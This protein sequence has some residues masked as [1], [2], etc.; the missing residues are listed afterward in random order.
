MSCW[1]QKTFILETAREVTAGCADETEDAD[2][3]PIGFNARK[4]RR[5][6]LRGSASSFVKSASIREICGFPSCRELKGHGES[7]PAHFP[8]ILPSILA[9]RRIL[10]FELFPPMRFASLAPALLLVSRALAAPL[11]LDLPA[12]FSA[13]LVATPPLLKH[14]VMAA[15][16]EPGVLYVCDMAGVNLNKAELEEQRPNRV[17]RLVDENGDGIYEKHTVFAD[18]LTFPNG[19]VWLDGSLYVCSAPGVW[20]FTDADGDGVADERTAIASGFDYTGNAADLHGPWLHPNGRLYWCHG[21]KTFKA[22][23]SDG[24]VVAEGGASGIWSCRPDGLDL[25]WHSL[26]SGDNPV[27]ID[28]TPEG[29]IVGTMN[30]FYS[31]PRGDVI[32]HWLRGGVYPREDQMK[33]IDG[34]PRTLE[35]LPVAHNF[36]HVAVSGCAFHRSGALDPGWRGHLFVTHFNTGRLTRMELAR[37][38][39]SFRVAEREFLQMR[40]P[41]AHLTDVL[42]DRDGSLLVVDTGGWFRNGCPSSLI[43]KPEI[44]G[45][46][47]RIRRVGLPGK[48]ESWDAP[49]A[50]VWALARK[51]DARALAALLAGGDAQIARAAANALTEL[52]QPE[53]TDALLAAL[54]HRDPGVQLA[55]VQALGALPQMDRKTVGALLA[56]LDRELSP[57]VEHQTMDALIRGLA[58]QASALVGKLGAGDSGHGTRRLLRVLDQMPDSPLTAAHVLPLLDAWDSSAALAAAGIVARHADWVP[59][60]AGHFSAWLEKSSVAPERLAILETAL[61]SR[62]SVPAARPV[63]TRLLTHPDLASR[64]AA[65]R[66]LTAADAGAAEPA[67]IAPL[68]T[69]LA[70]APPGDQALVIA[71]MSHTRAPEL[72]A[73]LAEFAADEKRPLALRL[74]ALAAAP[75]S[76]ANLAD[77]SFRFLEETLTRSA[78][79]SARLEAARLLA[80]AKLGQEQLQKLATALTTAGPLEL[81]ELLATVRRTKDAEVGSA[82]ATALKA[83]PALGSISESEVRTVFSNLPPEI[84]EITLPALRA[85]AAEGEAQ[86][87]RL[88]TL[89]TE[90]ATRGIAENGRAIFTAGKGACISCHRV[91]GT[92][93]VVGPELTTIGRIRSPRDLLESI[94]FPDASTAQGYEAHT[95][96]TATGQ[97]LLGVIR[98]HLP[99][100]IVLVDPTGQEQTIPRAQITGL[101]A[102]PTSL[103]PPG[104]DRTLT[105]QEL[106]D[107]VAF[108]SSCK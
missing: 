98:R 90:V 6:T 2:G 106:L 93:N 89:P 4:L 77:E 19:G 27:E 59:A 28:F 78:S 7:C 12:G 49:T 74:K 43:A 66:I 105:E 87:R 26:V 30:L 81:R 47:Y 20:K 86:R 97:S 13:T 45:A 72:T 38:G 51:G 54:D 103:M 60:A 37:D 104:L 75:K 64:R 9:P 8:N 14:P 55:A 33:V 5:L 84:F 41:D 69:A 101:Q 67:W 25:R 91:G 95:V 22:T 16:G 50:S 70:D 17:V 21:R 88:D 76:N 15:H 10:F 58:E 23:Q 35:V 79:A 24:A 99:D 48:V 1:Q 92:G 34:L 3:K 73:A 36:G 102:L 46:I 63:L 57:H 65:W 53:A 94:V 107:L 18:R 52:R 80:S 82:W 68:Q 85:F 56:V 42:E 62:A 31:R 44:A 100:A 96:E 40:S 29:E 71:A 32:I 39:A 108:L 61:R 11:P 83:A